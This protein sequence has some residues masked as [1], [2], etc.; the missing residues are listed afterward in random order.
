MLL[1]STALFDTVGL[2]MEAENASN[3]ISNH[4]KCTSVVFVK[5]VFRVWPSEDLFELQPW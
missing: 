4:T 1:V 5:G 2:I 3:N